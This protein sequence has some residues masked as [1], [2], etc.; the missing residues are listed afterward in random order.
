MGKRLPIL[1]GLC[2]LFFGTKA[3]TVVFNET[4]ANPGSATYVGSGTLTG[5]KNWTVL[6][7]GGDFGAR[8]NNGLMDITN[9][10][11]LAP[12]AAASCFVYVDS[13]A[14]SG[15]YK[16]SFGSNSGTLTWTFNIRQIRNDP[17]G[18]GG[19]NYGVAFILGGTSTT[20][21]NAGNGYA[22]VLG[23]TGTTDPYKLVRY[24]T[25]LS[26]TLTDMIVS[27]GVASSNYHSIK[28]T[29]TA[30]TNT[31]ELFV[32]NDGATAFAD[33]TT[34][35]YTSAGTTVN[36]TY[37]NTPLAF[38][39][40]YWNG[41]TGSNQT[42][43]FDNVQVTLSASCIPPASQA[44][45]FAASGVD[46]NN[47]TLNWTSVSGSNGTLVAIRPQAQTIAAP[48]N[49][50]SYTANAN[51]TS[52]GQINTNN[53]V[54][55]LQTNG[56]IAV[57]GLAA[58]TRY[59]AN[60]YEVSSTGNCYN[61]TSS[62]AV[63][64]LTRSLEPQAHSA[65]FTA[66][67]AAFN[68]VTLNFA[69][70]ST[71]TNADGYYVLRRAGTAVT[72]T[73]TDATGYTVGATVGSDTLAAIVNSTSLTTASITGLA[74]NTTHFFRL[75]PFNSN[76]TNDSTNNFYVGG[77]IPSASA[78]T[79]IAP[80]TLSDV[81]TDGTFSYPTNFSYNSFQ[82]SSITS[83]SN[84]LGVYRFTVRD[85]GASLNDADANATTINSLVFSS[86][87]GA[88]AIR[89][90]ALFDGNALISAAGVVSTGDSTITFSGLS[91]A[92]ADN[93]SRT[94]TLR[95]TFIASVTDNAQLSFSITNANIT[96]ASAGSQF[97][98]FTTQTSSTTGD[99]NRIE[100]TGTALSFNQQPKS[101]GVSTSQTVAVEVIDGLGSRDF[102][103]VGTVSIT[104][105][106]TM[107]VTPK[108]AALS[109]GLATFTNSITHTV[110][111]TGLVLTAT[112]APYTSINSSS[113][114]VITVPA[115]S[116]RTISSG[117]WG[118][119]N[120]ATWEQFTSGVWSTTTAPP[121]NT[122]NFIYI[123]DSI[124]LSSAIGSSVRIVVD[125]LGK[126]NANNTMTAVD[127]T[128]N[129]GGFAYV[130]TAS[131]VDLGN[132]LV[133]RGGTLRLNN[134]G[135]TTS[136][137]TLTLD[138]GA[139][140]VINSVGIGTGAN[141]WLG[142]ENF[143]TGSTVSIVT[144]NWGGGTADA[145]LIGSTPQISLNADGYYFGNLTVNATSVSALFVFSAYTGGTTKLCSGDLNVTISGNNACFTNSTA[146][147]E[148]K[149]NVNV[150]SGQ[151]SLG[152]STSATTAIQ[153]ILGNL[154]VSSGA[155]LNF[156]QS[157]SANTNVTL[158][159]A[160]NVSG[161]GSITSSDP[162]GILLEFNKVGVQTLSAPT[163]GTAIAIQ[164]DSFSEVRLT[165]QDLSIGSTLTV[166]TGGTLDFNGFNVIGTGAFT[167]L[168]G[169]KLKITSANGVNT[170]GTSG[171]VQ[172]S[173]VRTLPSTGYFE[174]TGSVSPQSTG[175]C[176][177]TTSAAR[178][179]IINKTNPTDTVNLTQSTGTTDSLIILNG[180][181]QESTTAS[182]NGS[183]SLAMYGGTFRT[184]FPNTT[185]PR[186]TGTYVLSAGTIQLYGDSSQSIRS[187]VTYN[188]LSITGNNAGATKKTS[189][190]SFVVN[191]MLSISGNPIVDFTNDQ[192]TGN[193]GLS[194]SGGRLRMS[195]LSNTT[196][197][198]LAATNAGTTYSLTGGTIEF[199]GTSATGTQQLIRGT[200]GSSQRI[201]YF[202]LELNSNGANINLNNIKAAASF[203][204]AGT[205]T[206]NS[207]TV[208]GLD[209]TDAIG[210]TGNF[211]LN[212][213]ATLRFANAAGLTALTDTSSNI[214]VTGSRS[215]S[216]TANYILSGTATPA[217]LGS[218]FPDS[219]AALIFE[220]PNSV[221][222]MTKGVTVRDSVSFSGGIATQV[223]SGPAITF[224]DNAVYTKTDSASFVDGIVRKVGN[225]AFTFPIGLSGFG[226][227]PIS[228]TA[229]DNTADVFD[230][231]FVRS[232]S[233][234]VGTGFAPGITHVS[235]C[236]YYKLDEIADAG[237]PTTVQITMNW[238]PRS[239]CGL[240][241]K[242]INNLSSLMVAHY[243]T[244]LNAWESVGNTAV[245]GD[246]L[247][248]SITS[249]FVSSF[250][251]F[252]LGAQ[253]NNSLPVVLKSFDA[254]LNNTSV[255]VTWETAAEYQIDRFE[256]Q[257]ST[258]GIDFSTIGS[259]PANNQPSTYSL[260]DPN[261]PNGRS[262]YRLQTIDKDGSKEFSKIVSVGNKNSTEII[263]IYAVVGSSAEVVISS[264]ANASIPFSITDVTGRVIEKGSL[265]TTKG[266]NK[267]SV[268]NAA[269]TTGIYFFTI[270]VDGKAITTKYIVQ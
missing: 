27:S 101:V 16:A 124:S 19:T 31:W 99:N 21:L 2:L 217:N 236:E 189:A 175:T 135:L 29:Y 170:S 173:G 55:A 233:A 193:G 61:L 104:S 25:G 261:A 187:G 157:S 50:T 265:V 130:S 17:A 156:N 81:V 137:R 5:L 90:A 211:V 76:G 84:S 228:I 20:P 253:N 141:L 64:F 139:T 161:P 10:A 167:Q 155:I 149:G 127:I 205:L 34:G 97:S 237:A 22:V 112:L 73:L 181:F 222:N 145:R 154:S 80:S 148:V 9:T 43:T 229:P 39:G 179:I 79:P 24:T 116:Y 129:A 60:A 96:A 165:N 198:Q 182:I 178:R 163:F 214:R 133:K 147:V 48:A 206:V 85:G 258:N 184:S 38:S 108:T 132:I 188:N 47:V 164:I 248:G 128:V 202:N 192:I 30:S 113:F 138:S 69:A 134:S 268:G 98:S 23:Q 191:G 254:K 65:T 26:G 246:S 105:T 243:N 169:G 93:S 195:K 44:T 218:S 111:G 126:F 91:V 176:I 52:A 40:A 215:Y 223:V 110:S 186:I 7:T 121:T 209:A 221:V 238:Y 269:N 255:L 245:T 78:T 67:A 241:P 74:A 242:Y 151:L 247:T 257:K 72:S 216:K 68:Q 224:S 220:K 13:T 185:V 53:R 199:Y 244:S 119:S 232:N 89:S 204:V 71:I 249:G 266:V 35:S 174:Y 183:G 234:T 180:I 168:T 32:R 144:W 190:G 75:I 267:L 109:S 207:P 28:V 125:S 227:Q 210:G 66:T 231:S 117:T 86:V 131:A 114:D 270:W 142:T 153:T 159:I 146:S 37:T 42:A 92:V 70:A 100:V 56:P 162:S 51:Y 208:F 264:N 120:T 12:T 240:G 57:S 83:T 150:L 136:S 171:N 59:T 94:L 62:P 200:Y 251:P 88:S 87:S 6:K 196:L 45:S 259:I 95:L 54:V 4:M 36:S 230:A 152:A 102:D 3:Q 226:Y 263:S 143:K 82:T 107:D 122:S 49:G 225:D 63:T 46:T 8:M 103:A 239:S 235:A 18:F 160:G 58:E 41:S 252:A 172:S 140:M 123:R 166:N 197:P 213:G 201:T 1:L 106:G 77:T 33:P 15:G 219:V 262:Y 212:S 260:I 115:N 158:K 194:M 14:Y 177:G 118:S 256:V 11:G 203:N 250:S